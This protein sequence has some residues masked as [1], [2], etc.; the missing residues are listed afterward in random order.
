MSIVCHIVGIVNKYKSDFINEMK[1]LD[2]NIIDL[3]EFSNIILNNNTMKNMYKQYHIFKES[4]NDKFKEL[5][6]KMTLYWEGTLE[7]MISCN[8]DKIKKNILIGYSHHFRNITKRI[9]L[10]RF[11]KNMNRFIIKVSKSDIRYIISN[12]LTKYKD[13]II[14]G[15]YPLENIDF[16]FIHRNRM[17]LDD[18]YEK[19]GYQAKDL[20]TIKTI[21]K[22]SKNKI[23]TKGLW[24]AST[25]PYN[26]GSMIHPGKNNKIY[27]FT[28]MLYALISS[29]NFDDNELE[30]TYDEDGNIR[31]KPKNENVLNKMK[32]KRY[33]YFV[34][35]NGFIPHEKGNNI[36][37]F[38]QSPVVVLDMKKI[39]N[40]YNEYFEK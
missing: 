1:S 6:R 27:A 12:N 16:D 22:M 23:D 29:F 33:L 10:A 13:D 2:Y 18:I 36:K 11:N 25:I 35:K 31:I 28:D 7:E 34:E 15:S 14:N 32:E 37:Y 26:V 40:V 4:K 17:K 20:E 39:S 19:A 24:L 8:I 30:K 38:C 3:D 5:D 21:F 9:N